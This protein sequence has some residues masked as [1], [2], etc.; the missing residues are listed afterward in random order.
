MTMIPAPHRIGEPQLEADFAPGTLDEEMIDRLSGFLEEAEP[1]LFSP[2]TVPDPF[3]DS[4]DM[5]VRVGIMTDG[6]WVW[7][8]AWADYVKYHRVAPPREFLD[9]I[10][11]RKF[12][13]PELTIEQTLEIAE[14]EGLPLPE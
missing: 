14:A 13:A 9:H 6:T 1:V 10:I 3:S 2:G 12:T 11:S 8:L 7:Q 5:H 4:S